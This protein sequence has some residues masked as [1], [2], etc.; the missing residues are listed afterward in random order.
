MGKKESEWIRDNTVFLRL[1]LVYQGV[2]LLAYLL[3]SIK[4]ARTWGYLA[5]LAMILVVTMVAEILIHRDSPASGK[6]R[7]VGLAGFTL[8]YAYVLFTAANPL[9]F[10]YALLVMA[11]V[12]VFDDA[13]F[14]VLCGSIVL[15][16]NVISVAVQFATQ[17]VQGQAVEVAEIQILLILLYTVFS[18][19]VNKNAMKN[20]N[21]KLGEIEKRQKEEEQ[22]LGTIVETVDSMNGSINEM[23]QAIDR[24]AESS[25]ETIDAMKE[26]AGGTTETANAVQNQ[27]EM[28]QEI[29]SRVDEVRRVSGVITESMSEAMEEIE[30]GRERMTQLVKYVETSD[31]AGRQVVDELTELNKHTARM[32]DITD[33]INEVA[34]QT[35][36]LALNASIEAARAG[37]S[38]RGFAVVA[39]EISKLAEQTTQATDDIT[40][41]IDNLSEKL[42]EVMKSIS[43]LM[44]NNE[45]QSGCAGQAA[46]NFEHITASAEEANAQTGALEQTVDRLAQ[47]NASIV[48]SIETVSAISEEVSAH[49]SETLDIS[50]QNADIVQNVTGLVYSLNED[51]KRLEDA[52]K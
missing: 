18:S 9:I 27:L 23:N 17:G 41:L 11:L 30:K 36:L 40:N 38:G 8:M 1:H 26:V 34:T 46:E 32:H 6:L 5:P 2:I 24:L 21:E 28:T 31:R 13:K 48:E 12:P 10:T 42:E 45:E 44:E 49:A 33:L 15:V 7:M 51:A 47:A 20:N 52:R 39:S 25:K 14:T 37:D 16:L 50:E 35:T 29:Q 3:E 19:T 43:L 22:M 4:G